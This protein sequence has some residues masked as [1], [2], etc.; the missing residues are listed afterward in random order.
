M[1]TDREICQQVWL[2]LDGVD[3]SEGYDVGAIVRE[4]IDRFGLVDISG[5]DHDVY[6]DIVARWDVQ[7]TASRMR[8]VADGAEILDGLADV[9][10]DWRTRIDIKRL[11]ISNGENCI[12]GQIWGNYWHAPEVVVCHPAFASCS[13]IN[14]RC[15]VAYLTPE[16]A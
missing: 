6:W 5:I 13:E 2:T 4:L 9:P 3:G 8:I 12:A 11:D 14:Q 15:W 16:A 7:P 10:K 1:I